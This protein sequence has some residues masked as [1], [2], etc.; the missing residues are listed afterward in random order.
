MNLFNASVQLN[1]A[2]VVNITLCVF[3]YKKHFFKS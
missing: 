2:T 3:D 1:M